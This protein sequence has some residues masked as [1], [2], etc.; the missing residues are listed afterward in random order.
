L[1]QQTIDTEQML[2][3]IK[4]VTGAGE[5]TGMIF[6]PRRSSSIAIMRCGQY[7]V[8]E[9]CQLGCPNAAS[10][11][12]IKKVQAEMKTET[13]E[14]DRHPVETAARASCERERGGGETEHC[15]SGA[16]KR[17]REQKKL[18][19]RVAKAQIALATASNGGNN[20]ERRKEMHV[21]K[22]DHIDWLRKQLAQFEQELAQAEADAERLRPIVMNFKATLEALTSMSGGDET[23]I[24][25]TK[26]APSPI[27][28]RT[29]K[30]NPKF[31]PLSTAAAVKQ[32]LGASP[33]P[34]HRDHLIRRIFQIADRSDFRRAL[35]SLGPELKNGVQKGHWK[36]SADGFYSSAHSTPSTPVIPQSIHQA[37]R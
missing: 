30:R 2:H 34:V 5:F 35:K 17:G 25:E 28:A 12:D 6:C 31:E 15:R 4:H 1:G 24:E 36:T 10:P 27:G 13:M 29:L 23:K 20:E 22:K 26:D 32:I 14:Q 21:T 37:G 33:E 18:D 3:T 11:A 19:V 9:G 16:A 8:S 7:Q